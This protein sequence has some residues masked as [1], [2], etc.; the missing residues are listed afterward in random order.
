MS[1]DHPNHPRRAGLR[2]STRL[3]LYVVSLLVVLPLSLVGAAL[4]G[5]NVVGDAFLFLAPVAY[6]VCYFRKTRTR[7]VKTN[8]GLAARAI[9]HVP[10]AS[11]TLSPALLLCGTTKRRFGC[12]SRPTMSEDYQNHPP[13]AGLRLLTRLLLYAASLLVVLPLSL[14]GAVLL[15][16]SFVGDAFLVLAP[17]AY[18]VYYFRKTRPRP[19]KID[20]GGAAPAVPP[21]TPA[22]NELRRRGRSVDRRKLLILLLAYI[23]CGL[24]AIA[25]I[26][27]AMPVWGHA[28][29]V[30]S[31]RLGLPP[32]APLGLLFP[33]AGIGLFMMG[34][35]RL[36]NRLLGRKQLSHTVL[37]L[38]RF[39]QDDLFPFDLLLDDVC[40]GI[41]MPVTV[42]DTTVPNSTIKAMTHSHWLVKVGIVVMLLGFL[43]FFFFSSDTP[44]ARIAM[45][46]GPPVLLGMG[47]QVLGM[48][49][50]GRLDLRNDE[51]RSAIEQIFDA[52]RN[53]KPMTSAM[54]VVR[55]SDENWQRWVG[56]FIARADAVILD[57]THLNDNLGWELRACRDRLAPGCL[58]LACGEDAVG[59]QG[60]WSRLQPELERSLGPDFVQN[61]QRF[62]YSLPRWRW[63]TRNVLHVNGRQTMAWWLRRQHEVRLLALLESAFV[64][65]S[66]AMLAETAAPAAAA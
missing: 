42:A 5:S 40:R 3:L 22:L 66:E 26:G 1:K 20:P 61:C 10:L 7:P 44:N 54:T 64:S 53:G 59:G 34:Y 31:A 23:P 52:V 19:V 65:K 36:I 47:L 11:P 33:L 35:L 37:W 48:R 14:L 21:V 58:V 55:L 15:G 30:L 41:A 38:R 13:R 16:S 56:D 43:S 46:T 63:L 49:R 45:V 4:L 60:R 29:E 62:T 2:L 8:P 9:P 25:I 12:R 24:L 32:L 50:G 28:V 51:D 17:V 57:V 18:T 27:W 6:T 39:H